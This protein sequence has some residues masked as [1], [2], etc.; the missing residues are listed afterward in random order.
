MEGLHAAFC[1]KEENVTTFDNG[2]TFFGGRQKGASGLKNWVQFFVATNA[3][4][5]R[6]SLRGLEQTALDGA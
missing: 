1:Q 3:E 5:G 2:E 6:I 4:L